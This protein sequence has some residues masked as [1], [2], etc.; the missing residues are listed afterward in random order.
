MGWSR[1]TIPT[2]KFT[3][4]IEPFFLVDPRN[5]LTVSLP[6]VPFV[7]DGLFLQSQELEREKEASTV[8]AKLQELGRNVGSGVTQVVPQALCRELQG[9][10]WG[11]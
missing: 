1:S 11:Y 6:R 8:T 10:E 5:S 3:G 7:I 4:K 2:F 9:R